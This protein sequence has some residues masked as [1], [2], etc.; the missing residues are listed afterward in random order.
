MAASRAARVLR[1]KGGKRGAEEEQAG[2]PALLSAGCT[3]RGLKE[4]VLACHLQSEL[5]ALLCLHACSQPNSLPAS[6]GG[7]A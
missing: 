1:I 3:A 7:L 5:S 6:G 4:S 2:G